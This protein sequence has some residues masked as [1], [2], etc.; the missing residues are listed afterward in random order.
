MFDGVESAG[1][2][3]VKG[4]DYIQY[5]VKCEFHIATFSN[6]LLHC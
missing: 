1:Y 4:C 3:V 2:S 6:G 5:V